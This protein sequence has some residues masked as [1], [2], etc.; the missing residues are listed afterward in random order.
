MSGLPSGL[1]VELRGSLESLLAAHAVCGR[2][3][4]SLISLSLLSL[5]LES[6]HHPHWLSITVGL[7]RLF[8]VDET[9]VIACREAI[10]VVLGMDDKENAG[11]WSG[12][13]PPKRAG[14]KAHK[15]QRL[16]SKSIEGK[17]ARVKTL[18]EH[19]EIADALL[20]LYG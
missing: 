5:T 7:Q 8:E 18:D 20:V 13:E 16:S 11:G 15:R 1:E 19:L 12:K 2:F 9:Q 10:G 14:K 17:N 6:R 4:P 3:R